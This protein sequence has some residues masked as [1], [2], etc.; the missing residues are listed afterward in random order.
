MRST[1]LIT[2]PL[3]LIHL[4]HEPVESC[5]R[6]LRLFPHPPIMRAGVCH[7][8]ATVSAMT[9]G[10][11]DTPDIPATDGDTPDADATIPTSGTQIASFLLGLLAA[12]VWTV[13][14][15]ET[16][17]AL[18]EYNDQRDSFDISAPQIAQIAGEFVVATLPWTI[19]A[20]ATTSLALLVGIARRD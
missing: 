4:Q 13:A 18:G 9:D 10:P 15:Y 12:I 8:S 3:D 6:C 2:A 19:A 1:C 11:A 17:T 7:G 14:L 16:F 5:P 20:L